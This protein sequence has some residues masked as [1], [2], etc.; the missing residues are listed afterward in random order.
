[1]NQY[2]ND[3]FT[4]LYYGYYW[5]REKTK[6]SYELLYNLVYSN[7]FKIREC[8]YSDLN[9]V[10]KYMCETLHGEATLQE[11]RDEAEVRGTILEIAKRLKLLNPEEIDRISN[12]LNLNQYI[13]H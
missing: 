1:M 12:N 11:T 8:T 10:I 2:K 9:S 7:E 4:L 3:F 5:N 6:K 13:N